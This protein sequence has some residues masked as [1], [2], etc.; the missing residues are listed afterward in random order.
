MVWL[1][2]QPDWPNFTWNDATLAP[3]LAKVRHRQGRLLSL[4]HGI[5]FEQQRE[6]ALTTLT[7]DVVHSSAIEGALL[8]PHEVR[9]SIAQRLGLSD[10]G[11]PPI[12]RHVDGIVEVMLDATQ[13]HAQPLTKE[14]LFAWH[15]ALFPTGYSGI[16][17]I[18]VAAWRPIS[19]GPMQVVSTSFGKETVHF[20]APNAAHLDHEMDQF[21]AWYEH[22]PALDHILKAGI[23]HFWFVTIHPFEDGNGRIGRAILDMMLTRSD[24]TADRFYS[25]S[26]QIE[27]ERRAYYDHLEQQSRGTCDITPWLEWYLDCL[28]R[29]LANAEDSYRTVLVKSKVWDWINRNPV[30]DRQRLVINRMLDNFQ[31]YMNRSKY[32]KLAKCS[33]DSALRD[34]QELVEW[35][36]LIQNPGDGR[37]PSY[38]LIVADEL[39]T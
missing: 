5:G 21:L 31:G 14:R 18:T 9:S 6:A 38:R 17:K 24:G 12:R 32:V 39:T 33:A 22:G 2:E 35:G 34:I 8:N 28:G 1:H 13:H 20:Q 11:L 26:A 15:A 36:V 27:S 30:N 10:A 16:S 23:A 3:K 29:A 4:M 7:N 19:A 25:L 37:R